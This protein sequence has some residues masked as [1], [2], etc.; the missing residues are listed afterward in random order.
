MGRKSEGVIG[1]RLEEK[2]EVIAMVETKAKGYVF[3]ITEGGF[4]K[5]TDI[6]E[7]RIQRRGGLGISLHKLSA[8]T[9]PLASALFLEGSEDVIIFSSSGKAIRISSE[10]IPTLARST[11]G[12]RMI[13]LLPGERV[14]KVIKIDKEWTEKL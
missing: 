6:T 13:T 3:T 12:S 14:T 8:K 10:E 5:K 2:D 7:F 1:I 9:G 11:Q 4:G